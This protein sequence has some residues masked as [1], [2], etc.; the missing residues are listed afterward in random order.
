MPI[1]RSSPLMLHR[2]VVFHI[3]GE[4]PFEARMLMEDFRLAVNSAIRAGL[5]ARVTSRNALTKLAY[6]NFRIE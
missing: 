2:A 5:H 3:H 4:L 1:A 6:K